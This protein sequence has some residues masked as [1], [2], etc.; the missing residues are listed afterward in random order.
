MKKVTVYTT[1]YCPYCVR[2]KQLLTG[3]GI[4]FEEINLEDKPEE[5]T[6]LKKRTGWKTVPQIF[7]GEELIG[8][9]TE[10]AQ[11][12]SSGELQKKLS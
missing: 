11:L 3:K 7:F 10:L 12:N 4:P 5:L 8:G 9:F 1:S 2:A 6:A